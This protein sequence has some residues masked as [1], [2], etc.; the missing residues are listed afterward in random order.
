MTKE[1]QTREQII[2][3]RVGKA[4]SA[5]KSVGNLESFKLNQGEMAKIDKALRDKLDF[6]MGRHFGTTDAKE[7]EFK[8]GD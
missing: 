4:L 7:P 1:K 3:K 5:L 2:E 8:L 6:E